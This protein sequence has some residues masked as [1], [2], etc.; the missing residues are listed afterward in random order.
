MFKNTGADSEPIITQAQQDARALAQANLWHA[1]WAI[2][3]L[4]T[5]WKYVG[6]DDG[7]VVAADAKSAQVTAD[8]W[9]TT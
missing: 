1:D 9:K 4:D 8:T 6:K 5:E 7:S 2:T 3:G